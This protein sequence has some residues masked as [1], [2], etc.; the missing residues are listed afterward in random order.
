MTFLR[1]TAQVCLQNQA[2]TRGGV[3]WKGGFWSDGSQKQ[4]DGVLF[5]ETPPPPGQSRRW[6]SWELPVYV[7]SPSSNK[8]M[9]AL[10]ALAM[11]PTCT[12]IIRVNLYLPLHQARILFIIHQYAS[13]QVADTNI[14]ARLCLKVKM[15]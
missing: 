8:A 6:E 11:F 12:H 13:F 1:K 5:G 15:S 7:L 4:V 14:A 10:C 3:P 2:R 9:L